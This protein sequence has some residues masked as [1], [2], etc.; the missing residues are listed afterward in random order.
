MEKGSEARAMPIEKEVEGIGTERRDIYKNGIIVALLTCATPG[1]LP[2][3]YRYY[4][5]S[6]QS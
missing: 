4:L 1:T 5:C 2:S 6:C 3:L